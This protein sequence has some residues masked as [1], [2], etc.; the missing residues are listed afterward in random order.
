MLQFIFGIVLGVIVMAV[1]VSAETMQQ[2]FQRQNQE[3][4]E[5][6]KLLELQRQ[7]SLLQMQE[8]NDTMDRLRD[9]C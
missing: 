7:N 9:P 4:I 1:G 6:G 8:H 3:M 2:M 5:R